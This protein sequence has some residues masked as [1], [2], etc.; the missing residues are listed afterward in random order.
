MS[1]PFDRRHFLI[2]SAAAATPVLLGLSTTPAAAAPASPADHQQFEAAP[3]PRAELGLNNGWRFKRGDAAGA[4]RPDFT[5]GQ[6]ETVDVPHA[7]RLE[8]VDVGGRNYRGIAWY[9]RHFVA[10]PA[11]RGRRVF[12]RFEGA[13][14]VTR[15]W[16]NGALLGEHQGGFTPFVFDITDRLVIGA[17]NVLAVRLDNTDNPLVPP[18]KPQAGMDFD[19]LGGLYRE[20]TL[21]VVDPLHVS[22]PVF[23]G[24]VAGGGVFVTTPVVTPA[25][26]SVAVTTDVRN[27]AAAA[28]EAAVVST[29]VDASGRVVATATATTTV[30]GGGDRTVTQT[31]TV[32]APALWSPD[33]PALYAL[34]TEIHRAGIAVDRVTTRFGIR[35]LAWTKTEGFALNGRPLLINGT[36]RGHQEYPYVGFAAPAAQQRR[37]ARLIKESGANFVR[38]GHYQPHPAFLDAC[39]ELGLMVMDSIPGWQY[40]NADPK[41]RENSYNDTRIM[42]RRDRNHPSVV[43]WEVS[44]N[45]TAVPDDYS[46]QQVAITHAE[47]PGG[48]GF[49]YGGNTTNTGTIFDVQNAHTP[50]DGPAALIFREYGDW[51]FGGENSTSRS[52]RADGQ[53]AMLLAAANKQQSYSEL[54]V[55]GR[56]PGAT[57]AGIATWSAVDYNRGLNQRTCYS[58]LVDL[59]RIPKFVHYFYQSQRDP[60]LVRTDV[61]SG[62]MVHIAHWWRSPY[63]NG[64]QGT[65]LGQFTYTGFWRSI[66]QRNAF[67]NTLGNRVTLRFRGNRIRLHGTVN[68]LNGIGAV[69]V[70]GGPEVDVD[71]YSPAFV[72][73]RTVWTSPPLVQG[74]HTLTLRVTGR[75]NPASADTWV[76]LVGAEVTSTTRVPEQIKVFSNCDR[77]RLFLDDTLLEERSPDSGPWTAH[78]P[79]PPFTFAVPGGHAPGALRADGVIGG[80]VVASH[81]VRTPGRA[82]QLVVDVDLPEGRLVADGVEF[83]VVRASIVDAAGTISP[84]TGER[85]TFAVSGAGRLVGTSTIGANPVPVQAGIAAALIRSTHQAGS[86][87]VTATAAGLTAGRTTFRTV[88]AT[89]VSVPTL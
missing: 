76:S 43:L 88:P 11:Y 77:I 66:G 1:D 2:L 22:D 37:D 52:T 87:T 82:E 81:T 19:Y 70:D 29:I 59:F 16:L 84:V 41:F 23:A 56:W 9:R 46:R 26:A 62:P 31:L 53:E 8:P 75:K 35:T 38:S 49:A 45:E 65:R 55:P 69:S 21:T 60:A 86:V 10:D 3:S 73:D 7:V 14:Q 47:Y 72:D 40:W 50:T 27:D 4:E 15:V 36:N 48:Q 57:L 42:I 58:G 34:H 85:V 83:A 17:E 39:D 18:G 71:Y 33:S 80:R 25:S 12:V 51:S 64:T 5:D 24:K 44:L 32:A 78:I 67:T 28:A 20:V 30:P 54:L 13:M 79:H 68:H 89:A 63:T 6:W 61:D 74:D